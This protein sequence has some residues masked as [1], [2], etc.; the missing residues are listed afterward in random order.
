[1]V[2]LLVE[3]RENGAIP[4]D[5]ITDS[6]RLMR[7]RV[8]FTGVEHALAHWAKAYRRDLWAASPVYV[9]IW[10]EKDA[11]TGVL[12]EETDVYDVPLM[13]ARGYPR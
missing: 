1:V 7:K 11:L 8:A 4:F 13:P 9:E 12:F 6:T 3:L 5:W 2:R 10:C